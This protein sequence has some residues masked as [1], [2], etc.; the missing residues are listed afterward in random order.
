M[1]LG[2]GTK[3]GGYLVTY[4]GK[5]VDPMTPYDVRLLEWGSWRGLH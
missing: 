3:L 5:L 2:V 1:S 4:P